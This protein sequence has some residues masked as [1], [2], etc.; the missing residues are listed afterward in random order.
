MYCAVL[1]IVNLSIFLVVAGG[2][3]YKDVV[4]VRER[5]APQHRAAQQSTSAETSRVRC[6][7]DL[8]CPAA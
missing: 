4:H 2:Y 5:R 1:M 6:S 3:K 8:A 7:N